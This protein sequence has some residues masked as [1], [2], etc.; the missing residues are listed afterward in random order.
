[1]PTALP[2]LLSNWQDDEMHSLSLD[3]DRISELE[4]TRAIRISRH[5]RTRAQQRAISTK[6]IPLV[7]AFGRREHDGHGAVRYLMTKDAIATLE[8]V[9]GRSAGLARLAGVY[10]VVSADDGTL[11]TIGHRT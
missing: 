1:V 8:E 11:I 4:P 3:I 6:C 7:K 10:I 9:V 5:A 2:K